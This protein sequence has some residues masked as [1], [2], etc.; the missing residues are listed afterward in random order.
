[1]KFAYCNNGNSFRAIDDDMALADGETAFDHTPT[2][3]EIKAAFPNY[4]V[5]KTNLSV[6]A[7]MIALEDEARMTRTVAEIIVAQGVTNGAYAKALALKEQ[8]DTLRATL[9]A[10]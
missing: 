1:M 8:L 6:K 2:E 4:Q 3:G 5:V 10:V 7:Q 9:T